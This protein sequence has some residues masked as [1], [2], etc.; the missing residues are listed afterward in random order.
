MSALSELL[1]AAGRD[2]ALSS[3]AW[4]RIIVVPNLFTDEQINVGVAVRGADGGYQV[5]VI[6]SAEKLT[7]LYGEEGAE[8]ILFAA[9]VTKNQL[10]TS[11]QTNTPSVRLSA[12]TPYYNMTQKEAVNALFFEQVPLALV[13]PKKS[14]QVSLS[15]DKV[16]AQIYT[17][18]AKKA[19][20]L[21]DLVVPQSAS[22]MIEHK[23]KPRT[24]TVPLQH[25][26]AFGAIESAGYH[27]QQ[28]IRLHLM[29]AMLDL[30]AACSAR[31]IRQMGFFIVRPETQD[32]SWLLTMDNAIDDIAWRAPSACRVE[33]E[34]NVDT[35]SDRILDWLPKAA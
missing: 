26:A 9:Q 31:D 28:I 8:N 19:P 29:D 3:G 21:R 15:N 23:G 11:G 33:V 27:S 20:T 7:C 5:R 6:E 22:A 32:K 35:L 4:S 12:L 10:E 2:S 1:S 24:V 14:K 13:D 17:L 30:E 16:R 25:P 18:L 34:D